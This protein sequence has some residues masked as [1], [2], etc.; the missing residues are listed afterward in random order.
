[1]GGGTFWK[2]AGRLPSLAEA[3]HG[4][5]L[6]SFWGDGGSWLGLA[7]REFLCRGAAGF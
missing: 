4:T 3:E 7:L 5:E 1:M 2:Q 6:A